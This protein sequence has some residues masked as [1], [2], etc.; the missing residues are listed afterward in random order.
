MILD[1]TV[2]KSKLFKNFLRSQLK[3][4]VTLCISKV[5]S[6]RYKLVKLCHINRRGPFSGDNA[7]SAC[8]TFTRKRSMRCSMFN[9]YSFV[10]CGS[11]LIPCDCVVLTL[12]YGSCFLAKQRS[13][14]F[15]VR[16]KN[17]RSSAGV[18][19][20]SA[21]YD[22]VVRYANISADNLASTSDGLGAA[23]AAPAVAIV[24]ASA[25]YEYDQITSLTRD[26]TW[27]SFINLLLFRNTTTQYVS[28]C[29][30]CSTYV[31]YNR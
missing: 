12:H 28:N 23:A 27:S 2:S 14:S 25:R 19:A 17:R 29:L 9:V 24:L 16:T 18:A 15:D 4:E 3:L 5:I 30:T 11:R 26:F 8:L 6:K 1:D 10:L 13:R 22:V 20:Y 31:T 21:V 7:L